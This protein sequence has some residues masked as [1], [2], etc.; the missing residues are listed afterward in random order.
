MCKGFSIILTANFSSE[1]AR[2]YW[3]DTS[4]MLKKK[5]KCQ[6]RIL[7]SAK[8]SLENERE[9]KIF[10]L[11]ENC[12]FIV[13]RLALQEILQGVLHWKEKILASNLN[14][15]EGFEL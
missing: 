2:R 8:S 7:Y 10:Q 14:L 12:Q 13:S 1:K 11:K 6:P 3:N 9:I 4:K 15:H 5:K